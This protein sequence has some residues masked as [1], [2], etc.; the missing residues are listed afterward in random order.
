MRTDKKRWRNR[1]ARKELAR[2]LQSENP[3]LEVVIR[4]PRE[5]MWAMALT[6]SQCAQNGIHN[7]CD[8][9]SASLRIFIA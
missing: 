9:S 2:R 7:R 4:S 3:G 6:M 5:S 8:G 1:K